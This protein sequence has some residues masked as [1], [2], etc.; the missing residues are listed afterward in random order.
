M[1]K[2]ILD[3]LEQSKKDYLSRNSLLIALKSDQVDT[4]TLAHAVRVLQAHERARQGRVH[5]Y[6]M[7]Q[8]KKDVKT[9][10]MKAINDN[11]FRE[12]CVIIQ[13]RWRQ[14]SAEKRLHQRKLEHVKL[15]DM[16]R[17]KESAHWFRV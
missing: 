16:V 11:N 3:R 9:V 13:T 14:K 10:E 17:E 7:R 12:R 2:I 8:M 1:I 5:A 6:F 15:L 4:I